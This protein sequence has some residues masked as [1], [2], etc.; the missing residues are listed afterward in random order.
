EGQHTVRPLPRRPIG[1]RSVHH[2]TPIWHLREDGA[3]RKYRVTNPGEVRVRLE[4]RRQ[5]G[6]RGNRETVEVG[7]DEKGIGVGGWR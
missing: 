4:T 3:I 2:Q 5:A 1:I 7:H 6:R